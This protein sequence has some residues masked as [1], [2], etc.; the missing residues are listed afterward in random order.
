MK[1]IHLSLILLLLSLK[2]SGQNLLRPSINFQ[3]MNYYNPSGIDMDSTQQYALSIHG[4]HKFIENNEAIWNKPA[5]L[6]LNHYGRIGASNSF[7]AASYI[8]DQYSFFDRNTFYAGYGRE[9][10]FGNNRTIRFGGRAVFNFDAVSWENLKLIHSKKGNQIK[11][12]PDLDL[13]LTYQSKQFMAGFSAKNVLSLSSKLE[14]EQLM[15]N[16]RTFY[17]HASYHLLIHK[18]FRA[19]PFVL[20]HAERN[21][22]ADI[23]LSILLFK[24]MDASYTLRINELRGIYQLGYN[25][26]N[27]LKLGVAIDRSALLPDHNMDVFLKYSF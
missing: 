4:K 25:I 9:V 7:Y 2:V 26:H 3:E 22:V 24:Q 1:K 19:T 12:S 10:S 27:R 18:N 20:L 16:R 15:K 11:F 21:T 14:G 13:G 8:R 17:I 6:Y 23:G 5:T